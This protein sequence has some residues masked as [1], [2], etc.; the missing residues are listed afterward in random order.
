MRDEVAARQVMQEEMEE[1]EIRRLI[2][3]E[4]QRE[5]QYNMEMEYGH[6]SDNE[7][8]KHATI[9][10]FQALKEAH[11]QHNADLPSVSHGFA[12]L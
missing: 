11:V 1:E 9:S 2:A 10:E 5:Y 3:E 6:F 8:D 7:N 12:S 4:E